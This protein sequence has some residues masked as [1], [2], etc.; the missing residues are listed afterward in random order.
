MKWLVL[1]VCS[2]I[3]LLANSVDILDARY[4]LDTHHTH[5]VHTVY[6]DIA[7]LKTFEYTSATF[8]FRDDTLWIY[9]KLQN[10]LPHEASNM[11]E[12][13]YALHD[14]VHV[15]EY[16][17]GT[18]VDNYLTGDMTPHHTRKIDTNHIVIP[19]TLQANE[20]KEFIFKIDSQS[21]LSVGMRFLSKDAFFL[22]SQDY[23]MVLAAYYGAVLI[24]ILYN[25]SLFS[26]IREKV[27]LHYVLF[28]FFLML[29]LLSSNG[30][31]FTFLWPN[32]PQINNYFLPLV[33]ILANYFSV[34]F[35]L[36]FLELKRYARGLYRYFQIILFA[37]ILL[38]LATFVVGFKILEFML[39]LSL[40]SVISLFLTGIYILIRYRS[41]ASKF[42][43]IAWS[44]L[45]GGVVLEELQGLGLLGMNLGIS[46]ATHF[47]TFSELVLLSIALAYRYNTLH[48]KM[49]VAQSELNELNTHLQEK[50][51]EQTNNLRLLLKELQHRVKNNFQVIVTF[52]WAQKKSTQDPR[53][54]EALEQTITR[55]EAIASLHK[56]LDVSSDLIVINIQNYLNQILESFKIQQQR[57][58]YDIKIDA[59]TLE[60]EKA[61][62]LGLVLNELLTNSHKYAFAIADSPCL[63][64]ALHKTQNGY[65]FSYRDNGPGCDADVIAKS[66]GLG[67]YLIEGVAEKNGATIALECDNGLRFTLTFS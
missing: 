13:L 30:L 44:V 43:V 19:Y 66:H 23:E 2:V 51:A 65:V 56:L 12:F 21:D 40:I 14:Y 67:F 32:T 15:Y 34:A 39:F 26:F 3:A 11:I 52:L 57:V 42:Y 58:T 38:L 53:S 46:H 5:S 36:S 45:L 17:H 33:F 54:L 31:T 10:T 24:M 29:S 64:V 8:G 50:V 55:I 41:I 7:H 47:G 28:H 49:R 20:I 25:L 22:E 1:T 48:Q 9:I 59:L 6:G 18:L 63:H 62:M 4:T 60:Y 35:A 61:I 16:N 27:Y 37:D